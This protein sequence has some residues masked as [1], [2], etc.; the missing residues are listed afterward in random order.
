MYRQYVVE[1][2]AMAMQVISAMM[3]KEKKEKSQ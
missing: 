1:A 2:T 3:E